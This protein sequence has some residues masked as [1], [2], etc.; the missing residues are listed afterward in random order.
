MTC[1]KGKVFE[2]GTQI[3]YQTAEVCVVILKWLLCLLFFGLLGMNLIC[4]S[5]LINN[6]E[7]V[8]YIVKISF[9]KILYCAIILIGIY[10]LYHSVFLEKIDRKKLEHCLLIFVVVMSVTWIFMAYDVPKYDSYT[11]VDAAERFING[12]YS[13]LATKS[14]YLQRYPYQLPFVFYIEQIYRI[15]GPGR[16]MLLRILNACYITGIF[17]C[18]L[19]IC[20]L[21]SLGELEKKIAVIFLFG[22]WPLIF[23]STFIYSLIPSMFFS[24]FA[25]CEVLSYFR[26]K[27]ED[28]VLSGVLMGISI[29]LKSNAW[30][31]WIAFAII[32]SLII[33]KNRIMKTLWVILIS[34]AIAVAG[35][36]V[37]NFY[38]ETQ[39]G[40]AIEKGTP[41]VL[42]LAMGLQDG[43]AA[44]GWYNGFPYKTLENVDFD[45]ERAADLGKA[46]VKESIVEFIKQPIHAIKFFIKKDLSQWCEPSYECFNSSYHREHEKPMGNLAKS[47]YI[48]TAHEMLLFH[49]HCYQI[50]S[51]FGVFLYCLKI[52]RDTVKIEQ[53]IIPLTILGGFLF[54]TFM[55]GKSSYILP[56]YT[57]MLPFSI[58]GVL[59]FTSSLLNKKEH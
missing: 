38:Y 42:W 53:L 56:Y 27:G 29:L 55:E 1:W 20:D 41:K 57:M 44:P 24:L 39:S 43:N 10:V 17:K 21:I 37:I 46:A 51:L 9:S 34:A 54:H 15:T 30:I 4:F 23:L 50:I 18:I 59:D 6:Y 35:Q 5:N 25:V 49:F 40:Y 33:A 13:P 31:N 26:D 45:T 2:C 16:Y 36:N 3:S 7:S 12:D 19:K 28:V 22:F 52:K 32:I 11:V 8:E 14:S 58:K 47:I 48:G